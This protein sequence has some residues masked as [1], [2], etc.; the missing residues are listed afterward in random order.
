[1]NENFDK[2]ES[3]EKNFRI[4]TTCFRIEFLMSVLDFTELNQKVLAKRSLCVYAKLIK[5]NDK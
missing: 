5:T 4:S 2:I 1:M 3:I